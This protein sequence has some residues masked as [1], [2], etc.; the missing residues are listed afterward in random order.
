MTVNKWHGVLAAAAGAAWSIGALALA[1]TGTANAQTVTV[2]ATSTT[3]GTGAAS[4]WRPAIEVPGL[5]ALNKGGEASISSMSCRAPGNCAAIGTY[6]DGHKTGQV[7]VVSENKGRWAKAI[8]LPGFGALN[9]HGDIVT[10]AFVSCGSVGNCSAAGDY[11]DRSGK[12]QVFVA[13]ETKGRW[14]KAI[15][16]PGL[17]A[18]NQGGGAEVNSLFCSPGGN[19]LVGGSYKARHAIFQAFVAS[20]KNGKWGNAIPVPGLQ[21]LNVGGFAEVLSV[22]CGSSGNCAAG[23][24][25]LDTSSPF[26]AQG[27][28]ASEKNGTWGDAIEVPGLQALNVGHHAVVASV[29]CASSGNCSAG[30]GYTPAGPHQPGQGFVVDEKN[31]TWSNAIEVP[32]LPTLN[33]GK[34]GGV[35]SVSCASPGNCTAGGTYQPTSDPSTSEGFVVSEK[36]GTWGKAIEI[37]HLGALNKGE[38]VEAVLV[39]CA[40]AGNCVAG[41]DYL[42]A[43]GGQFLAFVASESKSAWGKAVPLPGFKALKAKASHVIA[44]SCPPLGHCAVGGVYIRQSGFDQGEGFVANQK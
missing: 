39:S 32:G 43:N 1:L 25:Y 31:G 24:D 35:G 28:V 21:A 38:D 42:D 5:K 16:V 18:L 12:F 27:F 26:G 3:S 20:E 2:T 34:E 19:C 9:K 15:V 44:I 13:T 17:K 40:S 6:V 10:T 41:G 8:A 23:G 30:G 11:Q 7:F 22:S 36:N 14:G 29:S 4:P 33:V 37:P